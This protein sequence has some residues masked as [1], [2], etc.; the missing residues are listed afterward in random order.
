MQEKKRRNMQK[1]KRDLPLNVFLT[2]SGTYEIKFS[3]YHFGRYATKKEVVKTVEEI[4]KRL[5]PKN[6]GIGYTQ[7]S[8]ERERAKYKKKWKKKMVRFFFV[9]CVLSLSLSLCT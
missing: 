5:T 2:Q 1:K 7:K 9:C 3:R 8:I 4:R 6:K